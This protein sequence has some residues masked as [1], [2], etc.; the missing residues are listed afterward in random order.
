VRVF[1]EGSSA[2]L[3]H[4]IIRV[5][6]QEAVDE[7][8]EFAIPDGA[9]L[10]KLHTVKKEDKKKLEPEAIA[11]KATLSMPNLSPGDYVEFEMVRGQSPSLGFPGGY[12]GDRFYFQSF[13][14]P[15]DHTELVVVLPAGT[16]PVLDPRGPAPETVRET[17]DGLKVLRWKKVESR[18]LTQE[19]GSVSTR[20]FI[21]SISIGMKV[22]W[23]P[24]IESLRDLL[25]DKDVYDPAAHDEVKKLLGDQLD[26]K[27]SVRARK[28][29]RWVTEQIEPTDDV[30]GSA[31]AMLAARTGSRERVLRYMLGLAGV[32]SELLLARGAEADHSAAKLPD[33]ETYGYLLLRVATE[34]GPVLLHAGARHAPF[35]FLPPQ[36]WGEQALVVAPEAPIV[37]LPKPALEDSLRNVDIDIALDDDGGAKVRVRETH[38]GPSAVSWRNDLEEI[39]EAELSARFEESYAVQ[40]IPGAQLKSLEFLGRAEPEA[41]LVIDYTVEVRQLGHRVG[42]EQRLPAL[43]PSGLSPQYARLAERRTTELVAPPQAVDVK[44]RYSLPRGSKAVGAPRPIQQRFAGATFSSTVKVEGAKVEVQRSLRLPFLRVAPGDYAQ[45]AAFCRAVDLAEAG[46]LAVALP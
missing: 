14:V 34:S 24:Y 18:P 13:E 20:E 25:A 19:P 39:P 37:T 32:S 11:G 9:R 38:R 29:Y 22:S 3:T 4:N 16:E 10:L 33:P 46:E 31:A 40:L 2:D 26:A 17:K 23:E 30:F 43:F 42:K 27:P 5:Q 7:Q 35:G 36:L 6:S 45:L 21:P 44:L 15:F 8:G 12:V 28:I 1:E 41:P